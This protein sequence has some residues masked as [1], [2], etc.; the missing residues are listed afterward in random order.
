M[1]LLPS[2][3]SIKFSATVRFEI[4]RS[5]Y[6]FQNWGL[7]EFNI[8]VVKRQKIVYYIDWWWQ[9]S[10]PFLSQRM[11]EKKII[12]LAVIN[13]IHNINSVSGRIIN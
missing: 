3:K 6:N 4:N 8:R 10:P 7:V 12:L 13:K 5:L 9:Y 2:S 11:R 1:H